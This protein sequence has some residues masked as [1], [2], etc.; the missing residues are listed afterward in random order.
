MRPRCVSFWGKVV[1]LAATRE[2][3]AHL[4]AVL[5]MSEWRACSVIAADR[6]SVRYRW[7]RPPDAELRVQLRDL[8]SAC[9]LFGY[10]RLF[11]LLRR[12]DEAS[13]IN[14][15]HRLY[16]EEGLAAHPAAG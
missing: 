3:V 15:I 13:G 12:Q 11:V 1:G 7:R 14:R 10:R 16:R 6:N 4:R 9:R 2:V 8:A 5:Q